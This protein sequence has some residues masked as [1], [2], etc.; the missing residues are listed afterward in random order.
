MS[1]E[2]TNPAFFKPITMDYM[3]SY[4][5]GDKSILVAFES[6]EDMRRFEDHIQIIIANAK[7]AA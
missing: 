7:K 5:A 1:D 3:T 2:S 4:W 6:K